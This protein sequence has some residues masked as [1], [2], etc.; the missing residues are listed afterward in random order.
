MSTLKVNSLVNQRYLLKRDG[1]F[2]DT[3]PGLVPES[4]SELPA[5]LTAYLHLS[6]YPLH[7]PRVYSAMKTPDGDYLTLLESSALAAIANST[8]LETDRKTDQQRATAEHRVG[9]VPRL[10]P[11]LSTQWKETPPLRQLNWLWQIAQ[12]W[13]P[14]SQEQVAATL[15]NENLLRVDGSIVRLLEIVSASETVSG[16]LS[17]QPTLIDLGISWRSLAEKSH[18]AVRAFLERL[19]EQLERQQLSAEQLCE[20]LS[21]AIAVCGQGQAI[22]YDLTVRTDQGPTRKR[23]ED[24]CYPE[25]GTAASISAEQTRTTPQ[26]LIVCDGIGGH[27]GGDVASKLAIETIQSQL[28]PLMNAEA[29]ELSSTALALEIEKAICAANDEISIQNDRAKRQARDRMGTTLV[30][31]LVKGADIYIAHLGDSR[32]Y[33]ISYQNCQQVTLDDDVASRQVRLAG[34]LY[35]EAL[36]QPGAG[37]LIQALGMGSSQTLRPTVQRFVMDKDCLFLL[38]SDGLSDSDRVEQLWPSVLR[39]LVD[40]T[41]S[42]VEAAGQQLIDLANKYNGHDNVTVGLIAARITLPSDRMVPRELA[43]KATT[44]DTFAT[45]VTKRPSSKQRSQS[46]VAPLKNRAGEPTTNQLGSDG[47]RR[48]SADRASFSSVASS[49]V[50]AS[51]VRSS[52]I[53]SSDIRS[54]KTSLSSTSS[55]QSGLLKALL[56]LLALAGIGGLVYFL[57]PNMSY[58]FGSSVTSSPGGLETLNGDEDVAAEP[59]SSSPV[60]LTAGSYVRIR[61][62]NSVA[63]SD[64]AR[65]PTTADSSAIESETNENGTVENNTAA[66]GISDTATLPAERAA[67][68]LLYPN[69]EDGSAINAVPYTIPVGAVA[70]IEALK[71]VGSKQWVQLAVCTVPSGDLSRTTVEGT[72]PGDTAA[73]P[74]STPTRLE[75]NGVPLLSPG[76]RG[77]ALDSSVEQFAQGIDDLQPDQRGRCEG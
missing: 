26:L 57:F 33:R 49:N 65:L 77:W 74:D 13:E 34:G 76:N 42:A 66:P 15:L 67:Q 55:K 61:P 10:L 20:R 75:S 62:I 44:D 23:N 72:P 71:Q 68:I 64:S 27:Q 47:S 73:E 50:R 12:L 32:A 41:K 4:P 25:S 9:D 52:D 3:K 5:F 29:P 7:V 60:A 6:A 16:Q 21:E 14:F 11:K 35:R 58:R 69:A 19:C 1:V 28:A 63:A 59:E 2:L 8:Q 36:T 22:D 45:P 70:Q 37:S 17:Q 48:L 54:S 40:D 43:T 51:D 39:P 38:C 18:Q 56:A 53:R 46:E 24:A 31:A 30:L